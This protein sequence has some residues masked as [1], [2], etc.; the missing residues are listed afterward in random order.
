MLVASALPT[1]A[2]GDRTMK[3]LKILLTLAI[4]YV[5]IVVAFESLLGYVQPQNDGTLIITT[6]DAEGNT[7]DRVLSRLEVD[8]KTYV[9]VNHWPRAWYKEALA[10]PDV[11][12]QYQGA[13]TSYLAVPVAGAE[14]DS[15]Q[16]ARPVPIFMRFLMGF[17]PRYF[18]RLDAV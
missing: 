3:V 6:T 10:H 8:G 17:A 18:L 14:H 16:S 11:Q 7:S 12:I 1:A 15:V 5:A 4:V 13:T 9:A 2:K